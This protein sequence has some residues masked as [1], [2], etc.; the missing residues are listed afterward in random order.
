M[1]GMKHWGKTAAAALLAL[2]ITGA[3]PFTGYAQAASS[4]TVLLDN[5]PLTFDAA[6][7]V[8]KGVTFVPF[9]VIGEALGIQVTWDN[10]T[11]IVKAVGTKNGEPT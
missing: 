9:R 4:M 8:D 7:R 10:K 11:Q 6:P 1:N 2:S 5:V 3:A